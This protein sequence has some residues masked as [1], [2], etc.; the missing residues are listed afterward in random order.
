MGGGNGPFK[1]TLVSN[2]WIDVW[3]L[4]GKVCKELVEFNAV[5]DA[6]RY[7]V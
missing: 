5:I 3:E 4:F 1:G 7:G 2:G 6:L